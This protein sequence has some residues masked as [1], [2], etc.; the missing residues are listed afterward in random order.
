MSDEGIGPAIVERFYKHAEDY[1]LIDFIDAGTGGM[2]ILH[3]VANRRKAIFIDCAYMRAKAG[4]IRKFGPTEVRSVK[5]LAHQ[6]LHEIDILNVIS[7]LK[8]L[9]Q[10]PKDIVI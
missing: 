8:K 4:T 3:L 5:K 7:L 10:Q 9:D 2:S 6:S 1:P